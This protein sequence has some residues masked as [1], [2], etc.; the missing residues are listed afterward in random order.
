MSRF[1]KYG[2]LTVLIIFSVG[3]SFSIFHTGELQAA[4]G[5]YYIRV[6]TASD[7]PAVVKQLDEIVLMQS[8]LQG[9]EREDGDVKV[10][11]RSFNFKNKNK[12]ASWVPTKTRL[13]SFLKRISELT[14]GTEPGDITELGGNNFDD[15]TGVVSKRKFGKLNG[16]LA[17]YLKRAKVVDGVVTDLKVDAKRRFSR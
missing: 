14:N 10:K 7:P 5:N 17:I 2:F 6:F 9:N 12:N 15:E 13:K 16:K 1:V 11:P 8:T 3:L 4:D